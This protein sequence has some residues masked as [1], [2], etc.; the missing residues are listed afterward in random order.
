M[1]EEYKISDDELVMMWLHSCGKGNE[2][3]FSDA[4][5]E[6]GPYSI[7]EPR[8]P[9]RLLAEMVQAKTELKNT[10]EISGTFPVVLYLGSE[11]DRE[12]L[13][14]AMMETHPNMR[15]REL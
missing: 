15:S 1:S 10:P 2:L 3:L 4:T 7:T 6:V 13:I 14:Q 5:K 9:L 11:E 12:E 8:L